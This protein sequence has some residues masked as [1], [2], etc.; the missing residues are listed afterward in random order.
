MRS[1]AVA[2]AVRLRTRRSGSS[3][4]SAPTSRNAASRSMP[5]T[6]RSIAVVEPVD[7]SAQDGAAMRTVTAS[8][9]RRR[10]GQILDAASA[11]KRFLIE[12]NRQPVAMLISIEDGQQLADEAGRRAQA[13]AALERLE[14]LGARFERERPSG[15]SVVDAIRLERAR[16]DV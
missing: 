14:A 16:N 8:G 9:L 2:T 12:R 7:S 6:R 10:L 11:G 5:L 15:L 3:A 1:R 13:M 4:G